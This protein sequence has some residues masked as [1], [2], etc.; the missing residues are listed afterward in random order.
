MSG[1]D[2]RIQMH[3]RAEDVNV[4]QQEHERRKGMD[5]RSR[6][7]LYTGILVLV[8]YCIVIVLPVGVI[9]D[10]GILSP[11]QCFMQ[12]KGNIASLFGALGGNGYLGLQTG[13]YKYAGVALAGA[14]LSVSGAVY[15]GSFRNALASPSTLGVQSGGVL[16]GTIYVMF[17]ADYSQDVVSFS[18]LQ[19][20]LEDMNIFQ[21]SAQ[22]FAILAGCMA[23][24]IFIVSVSRIIG[25]GKVSSIALILTGSVFGSFISSGVGLLQYYLLLNDPYGVKTYELRYLMLGTFD[26]IVSPEL[27]AEMG[28]PVAVCL[29]VIFMMKRRLDLLVFGEDEAR[30]MGINA[31]LTRNVMVGVVT[32][33]TAVIISFCGQIGFVGFIVP[34]LARR[35]TGSDFRYLIPGS[36]LLGASVMMFVYYIAS[37]TG[38]SSNINFVTSIAGGTIFL[39]MIMRFRNR[40]YADWA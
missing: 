33:M 22:S 23:G 37:L 26:R 10:N 36:A 15:Q 29:A 4:Y 18:E 27:L 31:G 21:R 14:A 1:N 17:F 12:L 2:S 8:I 25:R 16:G 3:K 39:I 34:H 30:T 38:Y 28:L 19:T 6:R 24:V 40:R 7:I 11:A 20:Q 13:I 32:L 35:I 5:K 9:T